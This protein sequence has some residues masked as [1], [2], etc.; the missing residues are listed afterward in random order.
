VPDAPTTADIALPFLNGDSDTGRL[1]AAHDWSTTALGPLDAWPAHLKATVALMLRSHVPIVTLWGEHGVMIYNDA[2]SVF[3]GSRH[4][5]LLGSRVREGWHEVAEFND[6]VMR[7]GLAG[8]T[9]SYKD[10]ELT[11]FRHGRAEQVWMD[12]DYSPLIDEAGQ[13]TGVIAIV[14]ETTLKVQA[15]RWQQGE[16]QRLRR[17]FEQAPGFMAMLAGPEH[18]FE[19]ANP[20]YLE[21]VG[22]RDLLGKTVR[23]A[24]PDAVAQGYLDLLDHVYREGRAYAAQGALYTVQVDPSA[25]AT[26]RHVDFVL[27]P[28][29][30]G[31]GEV[32]GIF[33]QGSDVSGRVEAEAAQ[34][35][36]EL[37]LRDGALQLQRAQ[38]AGGV[39]VFSVD[40]SD[41]VVQGTP[42]FCRIFGVPPRAAIP[43]QE[44]ER[45]IVPEDVELVSDAARRSAGTA[46]LDVEYRIRRADTGEERTIARRA[47][48]AYDAQGRRRSLLGVVQDVTDR[49]RVL[50][51]LE[52]SER[53]FRALAQA[54]PNQAWLAQ[55]DG[56]LDWFNDQVYAYSGAASGELDGHRWSDMVFPA[57]LPHAQERWA[58]SLR[59]G[60]PYEVEFR[61]RRAD[62]EYRWHLARAIAVRAADGPITHWIGTN[63][64]I[65]EQKVA[66]TENAL[67]RDRLWSMSQDLLLVSDLQGR[68]VAINPSSQ[69]L[70]GWSQDEMIGRFL[71][72]FVHPDDVR[73]SLA[74]IGK[75]AHGQTTLA[76]ENRYRAKDGSYRLLDWTA[77]PDA[78]RIH[79]VGRD[80]TDERAVAR[81]QERIWTLSPVVK[82]VVGPDGRLSTANPAWSQVLGWSQAQTVGRTLLDFVPPETV[83]ALREALARVG[84]G[85]RVVDQQ[86]SVIAS[87]GGTRQ[88]VWTIVGEAGVLYG[89]GRD[90]TEQRAAEDALRQSQK[91]EAVGQLTGGIAHDFNNLLQG[92]TGSLDL[93][94]KRIAQ[95]R[96]DE[97]DRFVRGAVGSAKRAAAL[98]HRLLAFSRRQPLDP[99]A[100]RANPLVASMEDLLRRTLGERIDLELVLAG[101]LWLTRCD[102]NQLESAILNLAI[103]AR[104]AMPDGG[105]LVIE[106]CNAH[107]DSAYAAKQRDV[108]PGQYVCICVTDTGTGM[109]ADTIAKAF[110]PFFTTKPIGQGTGLG[111]SMIY[112]FARQSEGYAKIYSELGH[113]TTFKLYLPRH[114][115]DAPDED[116]PA[117]L[118]E[119]HGTLHGETVLVVEDEAVVRGLIVEVLGDLGYRAIEAADGPGGLEILQSRARIDLL[120][121]DIGLPGLNG[122]QVAEAGRQARPGL[123]VL[124]MTGYAENAAI[125]SGFLEPGMSMITK[126]FA[127]EALASR[128][129]EIIEAPPG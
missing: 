67:E 19:L 38:E 63:T 73:S 22:R 120:I 61:L 82:V 84:A 90:V 27:Q 14:Q 48:Y 39:G 10:Q 109:S 60:D 87:D 8:G 126:P 91:M 103:N 76:F 62:G 25:P 129:R 7:V 81:D 32:V 105:R 34:R 50:R 30:G 113:G 94:Q 114:R 11:L 51:E 16:Q 97:L 13:P 119:A 31:A 23:D 20:G 66:E 71:A 42:E 41:Q 70:L 101:G 69:R 125:A 122:R 17:M 54:M 28:L 53:R 107:L 21:L 6:H 1:I 117:E 102:P 44:L 37:R 35:A 123:K 18:R 59:S 79:A 3:A 29:F 106:T 88:I 118:T 9:L 47:E 74:E 24:L 36:G 68:I 92:I 75:L 121:T 96:L 100:V 55:P 49:R 65:H 124:F 46:P 5:Q 86:F 93:V 15:Q 12:L 99:R 80:I 116:P 2:Y 111:L 112:G 40:L 26:S 56:L 115:G 89:F 110:E 85:E 77:V 72:D 128:I 104:D 57:D 64:D 108:R 83:P 98:T 127:M 45:L 52:Q 33:V 58:A 4:P 78:G 43:A 95:G